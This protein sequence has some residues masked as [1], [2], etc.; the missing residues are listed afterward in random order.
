MER[1]FPPK[2]TTSS[3]LDNIPVTRTTYNCTGCK[4]CRYL[5]ARLRGPPHSEVTAAFWEQVMTVQDSIQNKSL[6][7]QAAGFARAIIQRFRKGTACEFVPPVQ[8]SPDSYGWEEQRWW[9]CGILWAEDRNLSVNYLKLS[10][11]IY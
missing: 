8:S 7:R 11:I 2:Q 10:V 1:A 4:A 6:Q 5:D 9:Q 3:Y